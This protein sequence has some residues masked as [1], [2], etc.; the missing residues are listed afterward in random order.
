MKGLRIVRAGL[1]TTV[2]DLGRWGH[3][4][5]GVPVAGPMDAYSHRLANRLVGNPDEAAALEVTLVGPELEAIGEV[6][7]A[8]AGAEFELI[9]GDRAVPGGRAF[10]LR[11]G[12]RLR[13][14]RRHAG[15]RATLAVRGGVDVPPVAGSRASSLVARMGPFGGRPLAPGDLLPVGPAADA[16]TSAHA[17]FSL[18]LPHGGAR[19]RAIPGPQDRMFP[20]DA[21]ETF[22]TQRFIVTSRSNRMGYRLEGT[23]VIH[24]GGADI[25]SEATPMGSVQVPGEGQP[26]LLM[27]D[28]QTTGGYP[29]IATVISAD[30][31]LAGQLAPGDWIQFVR[32]TRAD[33]QE[34]LLR[35]ERMLAGR[36]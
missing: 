22:F 29:K 27:A 26:I 1:L 5:A 12:T 14:G 3:Q 33:A 21:L 9:A 28:R 35:Q 16:G 8:L 20:L 6:V 11:S 10:V 25:L 36:T 30:L 24:A 19:L 34:A 4:A 7:C 15:A 2:Q 32:C 18:P 31:P 23:P 17:A 13:F